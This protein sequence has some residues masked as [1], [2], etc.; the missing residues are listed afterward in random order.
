MPPRFPFL[1]GL[2]NDLRQDD[3]AGTGAKMAFYFMLALFPALLFLVTL[4]RLF[5]LEGLVERFSQDLQETLPGPAAELVHGYLK[6]L[7]GRRAPV[8]LVP[9]WAIA[10]VWAASRGMVAAMSGLN[11][12]F[13]VRERRSLLL[14]RLIAVGMTLATFF[15]VGL[16]YLSLVGG[17]QL[18][19]ALA[20]FFR[21]GD[22]LVPLLS[23]LRWPAAILLP[24]LFVSLAFRFL[25][26]RPV[27]FRYTLAGA[28]PVVAG[29]TVLGL[30]FRFWLSSLA[31][32]DQIYGSLASFVVLM[33][34]LWAV[35]VLLLLGGEVSA[36][37]AGRRAPPSSTGT[38][39]TVSS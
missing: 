37:V 31:N 3:L 20:E 15:L 30:G 33:L 16:A 39:R 4:L 13:A 11:V 8:G 32:I 34:Y 5:P 36:R 7:A 29:W 24:T 22:G 38:S 27:R 23:T 19:R 35:S 9:A 10:A 12:A 26:T 2:L 6:D 17:P 28:L 25:P 1:R 21:L 18:A 14:Q